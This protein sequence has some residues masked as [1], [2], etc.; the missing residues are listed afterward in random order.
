MNEVGSA[1]GVSVDVAA[2]DAAGAEVE[3]SCAGVFSREAGSAP[4]AGGLAHLDA[5]LSGRLTELR[6]DGV[7]TGRTGE[8]LL[9]PT[10]P[11]GV[12]ADALLLVGLGDPDGWSTERLRRAMRAAT[13][14]ALATGAKSAAFAPGMLDSGITPEGTTGAPASLVAGLTDALRARS[15]LIDLGLA[16]PAMLQRWVFDVGAAR[17]SAA[18]Q[19]FGDQLIRQA[20]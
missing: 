16:E 6:R 3:L 2:W 19:Q 8:C 13:E 18:T 5:V 11:G 9:V 15:R 12:R 10:P 4:L 7:F 1:F 17:L 14:F 20:D